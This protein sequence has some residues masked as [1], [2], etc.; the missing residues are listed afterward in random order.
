MYDFRRNHG[1]SIYF[2]R[3]GFVNFVKIVNFVKF[4][5]LV[6]KKFVTFID[7]YNIYNVKCKFCK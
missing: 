4:L 3:V 7:C 6:K 2:H 5:N 1:G